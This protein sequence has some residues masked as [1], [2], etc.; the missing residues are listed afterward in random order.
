MNKISK[1]LVIGGSVSIASDNM[2]ELKPQASGIL[3]TAI[4]GGAFIP[5]LTALMVDLSG[6]KIAFVLT[7][8]T[9]C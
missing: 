4:V 1:V 2:G 7:N 6:F 8:T 3:C 5:P 9:Y